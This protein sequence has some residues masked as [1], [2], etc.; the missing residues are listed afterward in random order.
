MTPYVTAV[1]NFLPSPQSIMGTGSEPLS[2]S[3]QLAAQTLLSNSYL[4]HAPAF[5]KQGQLDP[6]RPVFDLNSAHVHTDAQMKKVAQDFEAIFLRMMLKEMRD[7]VEKSGLMG[8]SQ[9]TDLF[10]S[11]QDEQMANKLAG[12]GGIGLGSMVYQQLQKDYSAQQ[13]TTK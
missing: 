9:A 2:T 7:S 5:S 8:N 10:Q 6:L 13:K 4:S 12:A 1:T 11:M 3:S